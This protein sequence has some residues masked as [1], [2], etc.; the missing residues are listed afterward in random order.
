MTLAEEFALIDAQHQVTRRLQAQC[1][2]LVILLSQARGQF[3][4]LQDQW[5]VKDIVEE[6]PDMSFYLKKKE[7]TKS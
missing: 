4:S 2:L 5:R 3:V 1:R 6:Y 7:V